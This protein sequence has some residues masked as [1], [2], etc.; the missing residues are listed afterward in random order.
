MNRC[1]KQG[2]ECEIVIV[3]S[4]SKTDK[5]SLFAKVTGDFQKD[6]DQIAS[7]RKELEKEI[8]SRLLAEEILKNS[9]QN[10]KI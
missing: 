1:K 3:D 8:S 9:S 6:D 4:V 7:L 2:C 10:T 5:R